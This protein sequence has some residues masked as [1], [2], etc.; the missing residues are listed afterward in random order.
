M[1]NTVLCPVIGGPYDGASKPWVTEAVCALLPHVAEH[2]ALYYRRGDGSYLY[3]RTMH[4]A[5][6]PKV[7][8]KSPLMRK[9]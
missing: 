8:G 4:E 1:K 5:A 9:K 3:Q 7:P 2:F 6:I